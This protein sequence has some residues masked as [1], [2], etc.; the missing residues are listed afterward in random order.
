MKWFRKSIRN[1]PGFENRLEDL[2]L[3]VGS[4]DLTSDLE[5]NE[6]ILRSVFQNC[7]D[8]VFRK[9]RPTGKIQWLIIYV[10]SLIDEKM[11]DEHVLKPL[12]SQCTTQDGFNPND[13]EILDDRMISIGKTIITCQSK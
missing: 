9:I 11:L 7:S 1:K 6:L 4:G 5:Q 8:I 2:K 12:L 3:D 13:I 10:E